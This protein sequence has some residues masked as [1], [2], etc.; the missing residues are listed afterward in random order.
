MIGKPWDWFLLGDLQAVFEELAESGQVSEGSQAR[1]REHIPN[2]IKYGSGDK[3]INTIL[4]PETVMLM[5][6]WLDVLLAPEPLM[7]GNV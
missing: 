4:S 3:E 5:D 2:Q 7:G 1:K 6:E